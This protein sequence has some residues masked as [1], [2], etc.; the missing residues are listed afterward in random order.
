M[1]RSRSLAAAL[2]AAT[3]LAVPAALSTPA[4]A[5]A[6]TEPTELVKVIASLDG[7]LDADLSERLE[8]L[9]VVRGLE[10]PTIDALALTLPA[11]AVPVIAELPGVRAVVPQRR[12]ELHLYRS[13]EQIRALGVA[14]PDRYRSGTQTFERPGVTGEGVTVGIIDSGIFAEHPGF[15]GRVVTGLNFEFSELVDSGVVPADQWDTYAETT[16][17]CPAS[18]PTSRWSR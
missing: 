15:G 9:G 13:K 4:G 6:P 12:L 16:G 11:A 5:S 17:T 7:D 3:T 14:E 8:S 2:L 18:L 10:L 1:T